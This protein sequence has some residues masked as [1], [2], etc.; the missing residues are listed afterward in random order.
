MLIYIEELEN[1][2]KNLVA[3]LENL[4]SKLDSM[5][6]QNEEAEKLCEKDPGH[7]GEENSTEENTELVEPSFGGYSICDLDPDT[8]VCNPD[9]TKEK[10]KEDNVEATREPENWNQEP[11]VKPEVIK[12]SSSNLRKE[13]NYNKIKVNSYGF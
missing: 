2:N 4:Q 3:D 8:D 5:L 12:D 10:Q 6:E 11:E 1:K 9:K 13:T 7:S